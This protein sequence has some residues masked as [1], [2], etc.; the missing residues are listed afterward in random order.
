MERGIQEA[1]TTTS[2][3]CSI[4]S[5]SLH[6]TTSKSSSNSSKSHLTT[7]NTISLSKNNSSHGTIFIDVYKR[8][9]AS[10]SKSISLLRAKCF[11]FDKNSLQ[12]KENIPK[13]K[14]SNTTTSPTFQIQTL[15]QN[16][17][18]R[19]SLSNKTTPKDNLT[20]DDHENQQ[21]PASDSSMHVFQLTS[22]HKSRA[23][24]EDVVS[25]A[26]S[27]LFEIEGFCFSTQATTTSTNVLCDT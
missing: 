22:P 26:S 10:L 23:M 13:P 12:V 8:I 21:E 6:A 1:K 27:D 3:S 4:S 16:Q 15:S 14:I 7:N 18:T 11:C 24:D 20:I 17:I 25:D 19:N 9:K 5:S 2:K